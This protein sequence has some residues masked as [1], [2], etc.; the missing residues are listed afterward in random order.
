MWCV[1]LPADG[2]ATEADPLPRAMLGSFLELK[3]FSKENVYGSDVSIV[4]LVL[5]P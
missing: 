5:T 1:C 2:T 3:M 4:F